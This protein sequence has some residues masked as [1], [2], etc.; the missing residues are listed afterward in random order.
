MRDADTID[1]ICETC[2]KDMFCK[3][4]NVGKKRV[5]NKATKTINQILLEIK[6]ES[7]RLAGASG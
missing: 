2:K 1:R 6:E 4:C 7:E 3:K 5:G